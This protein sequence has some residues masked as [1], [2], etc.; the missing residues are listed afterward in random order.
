MLLKGPLATLFH[1]ECYLQQLPEK[2][3]TN[4]KS[5]CA[6]N[7]RIH[8]LSCYFRLKYVINLNKSDNF[9]VILKKISAWLKKYHFQLLVISHQKADLFSFPGYL[10]SNYLFFTSPTWL[11]WISSENQMAIRHNVSKICA[12]LQDLNQ[13]PFD[14]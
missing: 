3:K 6:R 8:C 10:T 2:G 5:I 9:Q 4:I 12:Q 14:Y 7:F 13:G 1:I 11:I